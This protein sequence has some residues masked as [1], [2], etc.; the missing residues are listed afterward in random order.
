MSDKVQTLHCQQKQGEENKWNQP[1]K[2]SDRWHRQK[3][4]Q[5]WNIAVTLTKRYASK[6]S[7]GTESR[8]RLVLS[9]KL[10]SKDNVTAINTFSVPVIQYPVAVFSWTKKNLK[11]TNMVNKEAHKNA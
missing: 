4:K 10:F 2:M 3:L 5:P 11:E 9:S 6:P 1:T 8:V 7:A